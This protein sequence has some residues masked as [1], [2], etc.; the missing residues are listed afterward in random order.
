MEKRIN[1]TGIRG[2]QA[3]WILVGFAI[4]IWF[5]RQAAESSRKLDETDAA[6]RAAQEKVDEQERINQEKILEIHGLQKDPYLIEKRLREETGQASRGEIP[7]PA[8]PSTD[9]N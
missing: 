1:L 7:L 5:G 8:A 9:T 2:Y 6:L 4:L 3:F